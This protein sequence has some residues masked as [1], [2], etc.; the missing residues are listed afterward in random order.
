[1]STGSLDTKTLRK[2]A[3]DWGAA[4]LRVADLALLRGIETS[5]PDLL[6]GYARA[7][8]IAV[9]LADGVM[10][11]IVDQPTP[12][13]SRHYA[14]ANTL[15]DDVA[16]R[17]AMLLERHGARAM[18]LPASQILDQDALRSYISHKAVAVAAGMGWQGKSLLTIHPTHGPRIR[19]VT[20]LTDMALAPDKRLKNR[21]GSCT[22]C[23]DA[24]PARAIRNVN[25]DWHYA[26]RDEALHFDR[27]VTKVK[28]DF[29]EL[30]HIAGGICG[31]CVAVCPWGRR[32]TRNK[33]AS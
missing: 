33:A 20:V 16:L 17:T 3:Q 29:A 4:D 6:D 18:P 31:V 7:V 28:K 11:A 5:P 8:S 9:R 15:L 26:S 1:M 25:T 12:A 30:P 10:D 32:K 19:L 13:Y 14:V 24:C 23:A 22:A 21:C 27:C 2:H